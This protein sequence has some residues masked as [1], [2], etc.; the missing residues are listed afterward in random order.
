MKAGILTIGD[1]LLIGQVVNTNAA[2]LGKELTRLG[3]DVRWMLTVGDKP[4]DIKDGLEAISRRADLIVVT[5]GLGP[6]RDDLTKQT[7]A[8]FFGR[9]LVYKPEIEEH[10]KKLFARMNYPFT[11]NNKSQAYVPEGTKILWNNYGTAPGM[12]IEHEGK[13]YIFLPGVPFEMKHIF[14][15]QVEPELKKRFRLPMWVHK[16]VSVFGIGESLLADR[17]KEWEAQL[18]PELQL[19]YLPSPKR[20]RLRLSA[21]TYEPERIMKLIDEQIEKLKQYIPDLTVSVEHEDLVH[22]LHR[23]FKEKGATL[24]AAESCTG[25]HI[26]AGIVD[27]A[28]ASAFFQ[29]G[30][31]TY[32]IRSKVEVLGVPE[33]II[34]REGVVS[35]ATAREMASRIRQKFGTDYAVSTTGVAGPDKGNTDA[36]LGTCYI[37]VATPRGTKA[38]KFLFGQPREKVIQR[39]QSK[40]YELLIRALEGKLD[41]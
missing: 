35:E 40:A 27:L 39:A 10:I 41:I 34:R 29:G 24:S 22:D 3:F 25:G 1:E 30:M 19:A 12:W 6:T 37:G 17:L 20:I 5:G 13:I 32:S 14:K 21:K 23:V 33:D 9:K 31:V 28:G 2:W 36:E 18:P 26:M 15:E 11:E 16:T 38:F 7:I 4:E 8:E